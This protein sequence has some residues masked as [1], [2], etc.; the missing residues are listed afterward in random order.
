MLI[1][2]FEDHLEAGEVS[3]LLLEERRQ[4][5]GRIGVSLEAQACCCPAL[6]QV[7]ALGW[8]TKIPGEGK[9]LECHWAQGLG[10]HKIIP[11]F[12]HNCTDWTLVCG[13]QEG[14]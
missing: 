9:A 10:S 1:S 14:P 4:K 7:G 6:G 11:D 13:C 12:R 2:E 8:V 5:L 3:L